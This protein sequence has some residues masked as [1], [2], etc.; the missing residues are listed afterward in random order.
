MGIL[1]TAI[2]AEASNHARRPNMHFAGCACRAPRSFTLIE[3]LMV[4][5]I[6]AILMAILL[7]GLKNVKELAKSITCANNERQIYLSWTNYVSDYGGGLPAVATGVWDGVYSGQRPWTA[8]MADQLAKAVYYSG[9]YLFRGNSILLCP[10]MTFYPSYCN[11]QYVTYGMNSLGIGGNKTGSAKAY[12]KLSQLKEPSLLL[13][14][15]DSNL[16]SSGA[17]Q[18]GYYSIDN[19]ANY[20]TRFRHNKKINVAFCDGHVEAKDVAFL[21]GPADWY[22]QAPWGNP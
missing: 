15:A 5:A 19:N 4:I 12:R 16:E 17:P 7:P 9:Q 10:R 3:L 13:G 2:H 14:F 6:I 21:R 11:V 1:N 8:I 22:L 18:L 20:I